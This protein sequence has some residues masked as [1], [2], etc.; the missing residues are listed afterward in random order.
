MTFISLLLLTFLN[1]VSNSLSHD[2]VYVLSIGISIMKIIAWS[3]VSVSGRL[4][5]DQIK[6]SVS[7]FFV[8]MFL[9]II[10]T[11]SWFLHHN[12]I[13]ILNFLLLKFWH[14]LNYSLLVLS[15]LFHKLFFVLT[16]FGF[17]QMMNDNVFYVTEVL[18]NFN[19]IKVLEHFFFALSHD[20][21]HFVYHRSVSICFNETHAWEP[22]VNKIHTSFLSVHFVLGQ[23]LIRSF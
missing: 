23:S 2:V 8:C 12:I 11:M 10:V 17:V 13:V 14:D 16:V 4:H 5:F 22:V 20:S 3:C 21:V 1:L 19:D 7:L 6:I 18:N 15:N 9:R